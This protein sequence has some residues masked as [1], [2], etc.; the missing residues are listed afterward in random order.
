MAKKA[1]KMAK[2]AQKPGKITA[3]KAKN[4]QKKRKMG[5]IGN[6]ISE[7]TGYLLELHKL[8]G[9]LLNQ[10]KKEAR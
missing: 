5:S 3:K 2:N 6:K 9:I 7:Y 4:A 8:Q 1:Q 10:L